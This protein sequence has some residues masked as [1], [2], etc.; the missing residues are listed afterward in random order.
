MIRYC[1]NTDG[2]V[3]VSIY[4]ITGFTRKDATSSHI[5]IVE[6]NGLCMVGIFNFSTGTEIIVKD[7]KFLSSN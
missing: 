6:D 4:D 5:T 1:L 7:G 3:N 2:N